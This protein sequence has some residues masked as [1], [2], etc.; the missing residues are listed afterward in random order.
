[1][2]EFDVDLVIVQRPVVTE[3]FKDIIQIPGVNRAETGIARIRA[4]E[5]IVVG[6]TWCVPRDSLLGLVG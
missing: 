6:K 5:A 1:V 2:Q 3:G 4:R